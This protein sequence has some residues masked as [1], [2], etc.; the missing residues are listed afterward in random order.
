MPTIRA[1]TVKAPALLSCL[2]ALLLPWSVRAAGRAVR[3]AGRAVLTILAVE[4]SLPGLRSHSAEVGV[5]PAR[6]PLP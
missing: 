4:P 6:G 2:W 3:A 5:R 1:V